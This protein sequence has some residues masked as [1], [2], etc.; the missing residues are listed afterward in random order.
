MP[1]AIGTILFI[2]LLLLFVKT[3]NPAVAGVMSFIA[4]ILAVIV[5]HEFGHFITA[6]AFGIKVTEFFV[7]F[8]PRVWSVR[9]GETEYGIKAI[10]AGGYV[11]IAGMNPFTEEPVEDQ[12]RTFGAKPPW[13]RFIVLVSGA[14]THF[15]LAFVMLV[16]FFGFIG[17]PRYS[18]AVAGVEQ[19]LNGYPSPAARAGLLP[20]DE[21]VALD[22]RRDVSAEE[23]IAY[24][25][26][27][28]G[29]PIQLV[30]RR[31]DR[32]VPITVTPVLSEIG[33]ESFGRLGIIVGGASFLGREPIGLGK[34]ITEGAS[35][36]GRLTGQ[37]V[38]R[39]GDV[40]GPRGIKRLFQLLTGQEERTLDDPVGL[41]GAGRLAAQA[42]ESG[43]LDAFFG[44]FIG[45]NIF[46]G[47][48]NL[49]PL[50]P[51]DGG[52]VLLLGIEKL[53]GG[54]A[55]DLRRV[56]PVMAVVAGFLIIYTVL[57]L[58]VDIRNPIP[59]PFSP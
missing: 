53:R 55:V 43:R 54:R 10:P 26:A 20:G 16:V 11:R 27:H 22:G 52:H 25:R 21:I 33:G 12:P 57:L 7:G 24:T 49:L 44:L 14:A 40:F 51:L 29:R 56:I 35:E 36:V 37:T 39:L 34:G 59:N 3:G 46:V 17:L 45:F 8:G 9:R 2:D 23:F 13:Q 19:R 32:E 48:L 58:Y 42:V 5:L 6:K 4:V 18:P 31:N 38:V 1:V 15:I 50:P 47:F 41:V 30:V 28:V